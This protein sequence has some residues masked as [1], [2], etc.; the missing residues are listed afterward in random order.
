MKWWERRKT[1]KGERACSHGGREGW[2]CLLFGGQKEISPLFPFTVYIFLQWKKKSELFLF[3][4]R[5]LF[6][7]IVPIA[8]FFLILNFHPKTDSETKLESREWEDK[9][10]EFVAFECY[11]MLRKREGKRA[12]IKTKT[13]KKW[14]G[15]REATLKR[16]HR[17]A[18]LCTLLEKSYDFIEEKAISYL[19]KATSTHLAESLFCVGMCLYIC[20]RV[21]S[22]SLVIPDWK[23]EWRG[24]LHLHQ[25]TKTE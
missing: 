12:E 11:T 15:Q 4:C 17:I 7:F 9:L 13:P 8:S 22:V 10:C 5:W 2:V 6:P 23:N 25:K 1:V 18:H 24:F 20:L 16:L 3:C 21:P 19:I 14:V